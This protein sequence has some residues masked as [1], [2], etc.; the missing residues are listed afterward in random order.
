MIGIQL[1]QETL[2]KLAETAIEVDSPRT[3]ESTCKG[4][5]QIIHWSRNSCCTFRRSI[6]ICECN[7]ITFTH[8]EPASYSNGTTEIGP[9]ASHRF[10]AP[11]KPRRRRSSKRQ[12]VFPTILLNAQWGVIPSFTS[13]VSHPPREPSRGAGSKRGS[14][15]T[16]RF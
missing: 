13:S 12:Y 4:L 6:C 16:Y 15:S 5:S 2:E 8:K 1:T 3:N 7:R 11:G 10:Q 14:V 9:H